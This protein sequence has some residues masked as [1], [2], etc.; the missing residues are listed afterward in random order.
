MYLF[1]ISKVD[2]FGPCGS[3]Q[4]PNNQTEECYKLFQRDYKFYLAFENSNC[5]DYITSDVF[6]ANLIDRD[7]VPV[8]MGAHPEGIFKVQYMTIHITKNE[9]YQ[10]IY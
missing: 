3:L 10:S 8:V 6:Y 7:I 2:I 9:Q 5:R 1:P 4:C